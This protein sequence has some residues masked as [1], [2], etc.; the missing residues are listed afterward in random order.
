MLAQVPV[1]EDTVRPNK[2]KGWSLE[3]R[4]VHCKSVQGDGWLRPPKTQSSLKGFGK[5]FFKAR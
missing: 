4:K 1:P 5:A 3:Q 2:P